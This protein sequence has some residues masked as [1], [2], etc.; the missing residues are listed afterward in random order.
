MTSLRGIAQPSDCPLTLTLLAYWRGLL[1]IP[2]AWQTLILV[3]RGEYCDMI[4]HGPDIRARGSE[5]FSKRRRGIAKWEERY[6]NVC[7]A[8]PVRNA[9]GRSRGSLGCAWRY[10]GWPSCRCLHYD[11][12]NTTRGS[13]RLYG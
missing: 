12:D 4:G 7:N 2:H 13:A 5:S 11:R 1:A 6:L 8:P 3:V 10:A 9:R